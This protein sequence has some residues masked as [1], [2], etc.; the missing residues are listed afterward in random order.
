MY[1]F[2]S[3]SPTQTLARAVKRVA[4]TP[5]VLAIRWPTAAS[6]QQFL[7]TST[8]ATEVRTLLDGA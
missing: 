2:P 1:A 5:G 3:V 8:Y 4:L 6:I 7:T